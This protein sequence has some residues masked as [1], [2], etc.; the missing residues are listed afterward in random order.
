MNADT[1]RSCA[2]CDAHENCERMI[3]V[4]VVSPG[5]VCDQ[6]KAADGVAQEDKPLGA[7]IIKT[8]AAS[9]VFRTLGCLFGAV[10]MLHHDQDAGF[11]VSGLADLGESIAVAAMDAAEAGEL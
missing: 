6:Y 9:S 1:K 5:D 2:T 4:G 11:V 10:G 7:G 3:G 8:Q